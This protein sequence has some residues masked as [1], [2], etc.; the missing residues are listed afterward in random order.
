M[1][2]LQKRSF[3]R[4]YKKLHANQKADVNQAIRT[5]LDQPDVGE[6]KI[7]DLAGV[8]VYKFKMLGQLTLLAYQ[9]EGE[10]VTLVL[11]ALGPHEN[12]YKNL[13]TN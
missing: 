4:V 10:N 1:N 2:I 5:I 8:R 13:K 12:F 11:L 7:G 6:A 9:I 3:E